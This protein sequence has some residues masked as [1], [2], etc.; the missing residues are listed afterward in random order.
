MRGYSIRRAGPYRASTLSQEARI[1][2]DGKPQGKL[3]DIQADRSNLVWCAVGS[4]LVVIDVRSEPRIVRRIGSPPLPSNAFVNALWEDS[5]GNIWIGDYTLGLFLLPS[6]SRGGDSLIRFTMTEGLPAE[7]IR[8]ILEDNEGRVWVGTRYGG[9][10]VHD[11]G[12]FT[13]ISSKE[14]LLSNHVRSMA[15]DSSGTMWLGTSLGPIFMRKADG[16]RARWNNALLGTLVNACGVH[17]RGF[18]WFATSTGLTLYEY[19][20]HRPNMNPPPTYITGFVVN[21]QSYDVSTPVSLSYQQ[22][23]CAFTYVGISLRDPQAVRYRYRLRGADTTWSAPTAQRSVTFAAL[24]PGSYTFEVQAFNADGVA[25]IAPASVS[26]T[27]HP[28]FWQ[29]WW[30]IALVFIAATSLVWWVM[31]T[32]LQRFREIARIRARI[33]QD[34][35][36][37]VGSGLTRI[38]VLSDVALQQA[39]AEPPQRREHTADTCGALSLPESLERVGTT[40]RELHDIISDVVWSLDPKH[41]SMQSLIHRLRSFATEL[42]DA[43]GITL[44]YHLDEKLNDVQLD[45]EILRALLLIMKEAI[46]NILRHAQCRTVSVHATLHG[47]LLSVAVHDDGCGMEPETITWGNGLNNMRK[48]AASI[49]GT[50]HVTSQPGQGTTVNCEMRV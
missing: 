17:P 16:W 3:F 31:H 18:L 14:G 43:K 49:G 15:R 27:I 2:L 33:S 22:N 8:S 23:N 50:L 37:E 45:A 46:T 1:R 11:G 39:L 4:S 29:R 25:D 41:D 47:D 35:H 7:G 19:T 30:F 13:I 44:S 12:R 6:T 9:V 10:A 38:S 34:L 5:R 26:F 36:D 24:S 20:R 28:P 40:A 48:R 21:G 32:R 42:C